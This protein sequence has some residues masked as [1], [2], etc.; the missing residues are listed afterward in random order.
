MASTGHPL[1][2]IT[3]YCTLP[4]ECRD[5]DLS[6][7]SA[8]KNSPLLPRVLYK[9]TIINT[10]GVYKATI[11]NTKGVYKATIINTNE[12]TASGGWIIVKAV[13][14]TKYQLVRLTKL[15]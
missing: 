7:W 11:I 6:L 13:D 4:D 14:K 10:K 2:I 3:D 9:A 5:R 12:E 1:E 8:I 15:G